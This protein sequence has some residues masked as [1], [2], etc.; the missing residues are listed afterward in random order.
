[1]EIETG[2]ATLQALPTNANHF[3][4]TPGCTVVLGLGQRIGSLKEFS[5]HISN[6]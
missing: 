1:M 2:D 6:A 3:L 5:H 4:P